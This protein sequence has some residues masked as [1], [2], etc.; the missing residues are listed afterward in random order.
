MLALIGIGPRE[1]MLMPFVV[2]ERMA[3]GVFWPVWS[4]VPS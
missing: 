1:L 3:I 2:V 4:V